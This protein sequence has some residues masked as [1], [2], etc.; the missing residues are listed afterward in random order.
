MMPPPMHLMYK[1]YHASFH[2]P[3]RLPIDR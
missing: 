1:F 3:P 2:P